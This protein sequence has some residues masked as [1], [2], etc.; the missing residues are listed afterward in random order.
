ME[1]IDDPLNSRDLKLAALVHLKL[2]IDNR[3]RNPSGDL[4]SIDN[5]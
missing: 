5:Q 4:A 1:I 3:W 2:N